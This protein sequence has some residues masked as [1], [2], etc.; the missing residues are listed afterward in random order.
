MLNDV[1]FLS[2]QEVYTVPYPESPWQWVFTIGRTLNV[3]LHNVYSFLSCS[4]KLSW[5]N[6]KQ[7]FLDVLIHLGPYNKSTIVC[8]DYF[9][10]VL[11][12]MET[13]T[14][15][16]RGNNEFAVWWDHSSQ[17]MMA[18]FLTVPS[19]GNEGKGSPWGLFYKSIHSAHLNSTLLT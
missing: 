12:I 19:E 5:V 14:P 17:F 16:T 6:N 7:L 3:L 13:G 2:L 10:F 11:T 1:I 15:K 9:S 18:I 8:M 4:I